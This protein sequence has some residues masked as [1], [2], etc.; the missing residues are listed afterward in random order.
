MA[1]NAVGN[2]YVIG[3]TESANFP[4]ASP[5][6]ISGSTTGGVFVTKFTPAGNTL[7]YS[8]RLGRLVTGSTDSDNFGESIA[9]DAAGNAFVSGTGRASYPSTTGAFQTTAGGITDAFVSQVADPT[10]I[11]RVVDQGGNPISSA[12]VSLAGTVRT[13]TATPMA[14]TFACCEANTY[15]VSVTVGNDTLTP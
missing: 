6:S 5:L 15:T 13:T 9:L 12:G 1:V 14:T 3:H 10:I 7:V 4:L 8:I 11:G 2:A